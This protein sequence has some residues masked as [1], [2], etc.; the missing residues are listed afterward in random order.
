LLSDEVYIPLN[1]SPLKNLTQIN[2]KMYG[3]SSIQKSN[4]TSSGKK[5]RW[6]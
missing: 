1:P 3:S 4:I 5:E 6:K 2:K